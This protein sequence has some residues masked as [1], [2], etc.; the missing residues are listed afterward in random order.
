M[1]PSEALLS[2]IVAVT[3]CNC[4]T[5]LGVS[6][7]RDAGGGANRL[8]EGD[9]KHKQWVLAEASGEDIHGHNQCACCG[10]CVGWCV[11]WNQRCIQPGGGGGRR[12]AAFLYASLNVEG[13][14]GG[15]CA[16]TSSAGS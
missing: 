5:T 14:G 13:G 6:L 2:V 16:A 12:H 10:Q 8:E 15:G 4:Q 7:L 3:S 1:H 9:K 11:G